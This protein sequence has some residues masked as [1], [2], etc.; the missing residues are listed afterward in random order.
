M[1]K[2]Q[3]EVFA[4]PAAVADAVASHI[5]EVVRA[6][7]QTV[8][9]LA[10]GK[11]FMQIYAALVR[12]SVEKGLSFAE[13]SSFNLDDYVGL[14]S[15]HPALFRSYMEENFFRHV[16]LPVDRAMLPEAG[17]DAKAACLAYEDAIAVCGGIDFRLLGIGRNG[18]IGFNEPGS[19]FDGRTHVARLTPSTIAANASDF[20]P[21]ET[22]PP[23]AITIGIGTILEAQ[24]IILVAT[25]SAKAEALARAFQSPPD[26]DC[27][28]SALQRHSAVTIFCDDAAFSVTSGQTSNRP[29]L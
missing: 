8:L 16:D 17:G 12:V 4:S 1:T 18:H 2:A 26:V 29:Q 9:G 11:T 5:A 19:A 23:E 10:T 20:A 6:R 27:P 22:P 25:G 3:F 7:P 15:N 13:A 28:A 24:S 21:D 14:A